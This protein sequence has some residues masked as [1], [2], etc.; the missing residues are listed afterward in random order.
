MT[1]TVDTRDGLAP[2]EPEIESLAIDWLGPVGER[3]WEDFLARV[4]RTL[5][6]ELP[7]DMSHPVILRVQRLARAAWNEAND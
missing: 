4:E 1:G 7:A 2:L 5:D 6:V 3:S